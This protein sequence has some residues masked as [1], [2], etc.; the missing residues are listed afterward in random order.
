[1]KN[2]INYIIGI[3]FAIATVWLILLSAPKI[4]ELYFPTYEIEIKTDTVVTEKHDTI[5]LTNT[6]P[7][8]VIK[9]K[10]VVDTLKTTD[11]VKVPVEVPLSLQKYEG[12]TLS[13]D[14]TKVHYKASISGY[15]QSLDTLW[16]DVERQD[17][18]I[19]KEVIKWKNRRWSISPSIGVGY[20]VTTK[21]PDIFVGIGVSYDLW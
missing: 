17:R 6:K 3:T 15:R 4:K 8:T 7:Y 13:T 21:K 14:G 5:L 18:T 9:Y 20:G 10:T 16:F 19:T 2:Y 1:M 12:D 11:S